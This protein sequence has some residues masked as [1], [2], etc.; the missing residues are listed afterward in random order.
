MG[1]A[2]LSV[3]NLLE[4][5]RKKITLCLIP[6]LIL[7]STSLF[8][9]DYTIFQPTDGPTS[10]KYNDG[11]GITVGMKFQSSVNG[12]INGIRYYKAPGTTGTHTGT[13]WTSNGTRLAEIVFMNESAS[14]WQQAIFNSQ[15]AITAN[16][17]YLATYYSESGDYAA[18]NP[19]FTQPVVNGPLRALAADEEGPNGIYLYSVA[20]AF[21]FAG[22]M[23]PNYWVDV[24]FSTTFMP[25]VTP[26]AIVSYIP[27]AGTTNAAIN[28]PIAV[29]FTENMTPASFTTSTFILKDAANNQVPAFI[30][31]AFNE[32]ML[33]P[34]SPLTNSSTYT[35]TIKGGAS[36]VKDLSGNGLSKD[37]TWSFATKPL[38]VPEGFG[39]SILALS[40]AANPFSRYTAEILRAEGLNGF[41]IKDITQTSAADL[42]TYDVVILGEMPLNAAQVTLLTNWVN[43]GGTL[44]TFRPSAELSSLLGIT[45]VNT[46]LS[47]QYLKVNTASG[48]GAGIVGSTMQYHGDADL[49]TL[50]GATSIATLYSNATTATTY[51][52]VTIKTVGSNG[53]K[54]VAFTYDLSKSIV[55]TRQG[56]PAWAGQKRTSTEGP[57]RSN[58]LYTGV[59]GPDWIDFN[60]I[61]V[62][63]ADEQQRLLANIILQGSL[64][65]KP[66]PRLW[67][68]PSGHKAAVVM[69]GDDHF[70]NGTTGQF[71]HMMTHG[72]NTATDIADWKAVRGT[73]YIYSGTLTNAAASQFEAQGFEV[74]LHLSTGCTDFTAAS[75]QNNLGQQLTQFKQMYP[76][77]PAPSTSRTHCIAWSDWATAAKVEAQNGI[78]LDVNYYYWPGTWVQ[79]RPG[80]FTGSGMPMRFAD[81][82]GTMIDCYQVPTQLTDESEISYAPFINQLLNKALGSEGYYGVFTTNMHT[83]SSVH[84][85]ANAVIDAATAR[86]V[87]II[88]ARQLLKWLDGRN[89]TSF[90]NTTWTNNVLTFNI[91]AG[92]DARNLRAMLPYVA[93]NGGQLT[94][95]TRNGTAL[96]FTVETIKGMQYALFPAAVG[97]ATY[98]ATYKSGP[99]VTLQPVNTG[100][101]LSQQVSLKSTATGT[102]V[103]TVQWQSSPNGTTWTTVTGATNGTY[104]FTPVAADNNKQ[105]RAIWTNTGGVTNSAIAILTI[106]AAPV[107]TSSLT[108]NA[109]TST[110]FSYA[111]T[112]STTGT[113]FTWTRA[114]VAGISNAA[115]TGTGNV[116]ET[117]VNTSGA[118]VNVTY[119][120]KLTTPSGC[121]N[122][123]NVVVTVSPVA[124]TVS[125]S[126]VFNFNNNKISKGKF[127]WFNSAI[128]PSN[129]GNG[130]VHFFVKNSKITYRANN[131]D[132]VIT[133]P[134]AVVKFDAAVSMNASATQWANNAWKTTVPLTGE[135]N[136]FMTGLSYLVPNDLPANISNVKWSADISSD[137]PGVVIKWKWAAAVYSS[138]AGNAGL[139]V[140]PIDAPLQIFGSSIDEAG[141]PMNYRVYV[142][143]GATGQ[144]LINIASV[145]SGIFGG[146]LS[147][148][149][150]LNYT[151]SYSSALQGNC[152]TGMTSR[153]NREIVVITPNSVRDRIEEKMNPVNQKLDVTAMPNPS[154]SYFTVVIKGD[155]RQNATIRIVDV[156]G[157]IVEQ[158]QNMKPNS[159]LKVG[160]N[161]K[162][163]MYIVEVIQGQERQV[164]KLIKAN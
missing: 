133:V 25:D 52:A 135:G 105:Y 144:G 147:N 35:V 16:T 91:T 11:Q 145:L 14:G 104:T 29:A 90:S 157:R 83:D 80:M 89:S 161:W 95:L 56:N 127:I 117:L 148:L 39:G 158:Y 13:L 63:Q 81:K 17:T 113:T 75:L 27:D 111:A 96:A 5:M 4:L 107:L 142:I 51:P 44:I 92:N 66:M 137:K 130:P 46:T 125:S 47:N 109:I 87:P 70:N 110:A 134:D 37:L 102:P 120:Y 100:A 68:L 43:A 23:S 65:R 21:P 124:C 42:A 114:A 41:T 97:T 53:G 38:P 10:A 116:Q 112:S 140:K 31:V 28:E 49:Y 36:G 108:A 132:V 76:G 50:N 85:G 19:Y 118:S 26:P 24:V 62:P 88:S 60:K 139:T 33:T 146:N 45:K 40:A 128:D 163:G 55:Y 67:Y 6:L 84:S 154:T 64:N 30:N 20:P 136:V 143:P 115:G 156:T 82:D 79:D 138:F 12:Y 78:R 73:S 74:A 94:T 119:V 121:T 86:N 1:G 149:D 155:S 93:A 122:T 2:C 153:G 159:V 106:N 57:I 160:D 32:A 150:I 58:D 22:F 141:T 3:F 9:Q 98:V 72:P 151:G 131:Q 15:V 34:F 71:N 7:V 59:N 129:L 164:V 123:Q 54:A 61:D 48:P 103:P 69:T 99:V 162:A 101:C 152:A 18:T 8:A 126:I 77:V